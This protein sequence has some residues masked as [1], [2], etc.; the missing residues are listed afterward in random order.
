AGVRRV[1]FA[2]FFA[3]QPL[4]VY[5]AAYHSRDCDDKAVH[6]FSAMY[7]QAPAERR[8]ALGTALEPFVRAH[9]HDAAWWRTAFRLR[10]TA[11]YPL[12][13]VA[14]ALFHRPERHFTESVRDGLFA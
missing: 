4:V 11:T 7:W 2:F 13:N 1:V 12:A 3:L 8:A 5:V 10:Q 9:E 6:F 14:I